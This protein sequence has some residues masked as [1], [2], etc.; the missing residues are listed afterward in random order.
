M[1]KEHWDVENTLILPHKVA[2]LWGRATCIHSYTDPYWLQFHWLILSD[3]RHWPYPQILPLPRV[4]WHSPTVWP[5]QV[6]VTLSL[7]SMRRELQ[8]GK[9]DNSWK[10]LSMVLALSTQQVLVD[11]NQ[12]ASYGAWYMEL[13]DKCSHY[14]KNILF[15]PLGSTAYLPFPDTS[16]MTSFSSTPLYSF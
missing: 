15:F 3:A 1:G 10:R 11:F 2:V 9:D 5:Y 13:L 4:G 12:S 7:L 8:W 14:Y 16:E 6:T